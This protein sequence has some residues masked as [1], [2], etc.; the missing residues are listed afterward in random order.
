MPKLT[1]PR[2]ALTELG[3]PQTPV[4]G[5]IEKAV[6]RFKDNGYVQAK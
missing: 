3:L 4:R 6:N 2:K 1:C 5:A